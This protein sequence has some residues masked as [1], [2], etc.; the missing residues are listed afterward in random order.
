LKISPQRR[1]GAKRSQRRTH[2][3]ATW[4]PLWRQTSA[5]CLLRAACWTFMAGRICVHI[6]HPPGAR[7]SLPLSP[8]F[9]LPQPVYPPRAAPNKPSWRRPIDEGPSSASWASL[10]ACWLA[11][12]PP[13]ELGEL[14]LDWRPTLEELSAL[15]L[16]CQFVS[17]AVKGKR[18]EARGKR[19]SG[20]Q[21]LPVASPEEVSLSRREEKNAHQFELK[22]QTSSASDAHQ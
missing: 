14:R 9:L 17:R 18:Q 3:G 21:S 1:G 2:F 7:D 8:L 19:R 20:E 6:C 15:L 16:G 13:A 10:A 5:G 22:M 4:E 11:R 12:W